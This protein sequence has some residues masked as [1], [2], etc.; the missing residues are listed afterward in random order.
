VRTHTLTQTADVEIVVRVD[1]N[2]A[3]M[4]QRHRTVESFAT[5]PFLTA[6]ARLSAA[7][8]PFAWYRAF[9]LDQPYDDSPASTHCITAYRKLPMS[10]AEATSR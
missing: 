7:V 3:Q 6:T 5:P 10:I 1:D 4:E 2:G 9:R 8:E